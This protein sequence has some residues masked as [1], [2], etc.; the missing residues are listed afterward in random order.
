M[1]RRGGA[2]CMSGMPHTKCVT[3]F[4][5]QHAKIATRNGLVGHWLVADLAVLMAGHSCRCLCT[6]AKG[7]HEEALVSNHVCV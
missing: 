3:S 6:S 4:T 2:A 7:V 5:R 1:V